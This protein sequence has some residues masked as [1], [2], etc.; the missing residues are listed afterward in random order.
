MIDAN[1]TPFSPAGP[2]TAS[3]QPLPSRSSRIAASV[4]CTPLPQRPMAFRTST[5]SS[6]ITTYTGLSAAPVKT[7]RSYPAFLIAGD[8]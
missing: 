4:S 8:R 1:I 6:S 7:M 2:I 5:V 3:C